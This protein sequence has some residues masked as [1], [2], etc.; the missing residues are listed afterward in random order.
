MNTVQ[1]IMRIDIVLDN[2]GEAATLHWDRE[3]M[4]WRVVGPV[5][6]RYAKLM[7]Y[8]VDWMRNVDN[9]DNAKLLKE[10]AKND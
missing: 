6:P 7:T 1:Q 5:Y 10:R 8:L 2:D 4:M 3:T 9:Q